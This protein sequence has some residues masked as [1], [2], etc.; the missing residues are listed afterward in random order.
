MKKSAIRKLKK[1]GK[2]NAALKAKIQACK[3]HDNENYE[4]FKEYAQL[5]AMFL[6]DGGTAVIMSPWGEAVEFK[7]ETINQYFN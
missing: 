5:S 3:T 4:M 6:N 2:V 1:A 7:K